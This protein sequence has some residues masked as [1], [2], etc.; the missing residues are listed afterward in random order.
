[1]RTGDVVNQLFDE[2]CLA[3]A[4]AA[5]KADLT[6]TG[7]GSQ[8]VDD[9]DPGL[10]NLGLSLLLLEARGRAVDRPAVN[11]VYG[12]HVVEGVAQ[13]VEEPAQGGRT[14]GHRDG[15]AGVGSDGAAAQAVRVRQGQRAHPVV[16]QVLL[17]FSDHR[18]A[19]LVDLDGVVHAGKV[20]RREL[21][22]H[23]G[24]DYLNHA[25]LSACCHNDLPVL[26]AAPSGA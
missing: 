26:P 22:V 14:D 13:H 12:A 10:Q 16:T 17:H 7:Q 3:H 15:R 4:G 9:F 24:T 25:A 11:G 23:D 1:V 21:D 20:V 8:Q 19:V 5:V 18:R 2:H 6:T